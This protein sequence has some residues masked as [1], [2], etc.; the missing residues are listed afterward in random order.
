M[1]TFRNFQLAMAIYFEHPARAK[2]LLWPLHLLKLNSS[3]ILFMIVNLSSLLFG[4]GD[5]HFDER[6]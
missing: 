1:C 4:G 6:H 2:C 3:V 5:A